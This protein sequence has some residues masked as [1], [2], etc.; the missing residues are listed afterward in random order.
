M[1]EICI[2]HYI[3]QLAISEVMKAG[4][5]IKA[6]RQSC[7]SVLVAGVTKIRW[8]KRSIT[9]QSYTAFDAHSKYGFCHVGELSENTETATL[10][11]YC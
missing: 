1:H 11:L 5:R 9:W 8:V 6:M 3:F 7:S 2:E 4:G 10:F